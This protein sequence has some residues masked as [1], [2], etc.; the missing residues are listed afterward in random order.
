MDRT[1]GA[2]VQPDSDLFKDQLTNNKFLI[3]L[4]RDKTKITDTNERGYHVTSL[5]LHASKENKGML[6]KLNTHKLENLGA[7]L[8]GMNCHISSNVK[9]II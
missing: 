2:C 6:Q 8:K 5:Y 7:I 4:T 3:S 9:Q 1:W